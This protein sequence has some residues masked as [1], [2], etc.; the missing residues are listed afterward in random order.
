VFCENKRSD[1]D[2]KGYIKLNGFSQYF[3]LCDVWYYKISRYICFAMINFILIFFYLVLGLILQRIKWFPSTSYK[4]LNK[5]VIYISGFKFYYIQKF[6][7]IIDCYSTGVAWLHLFC[8]SYF[9][10]LE[11]FN[12]SKKLTGCLILTAGLG[13]TSS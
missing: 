11:K 12:W 1:L 10:F 2:G 3:Y 8:L 4:L 13:N 5:I 6:I 7:G 9:L